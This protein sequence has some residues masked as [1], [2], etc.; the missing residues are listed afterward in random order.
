M[1]IAKQNMRCFSK[2]VDRL[3]SILLLLCG[4]VVFWTISQVTAFVSFRI[5]SD[6]MEPALLPGDNILVNKWIMGGRIF[7]IWDASEKKDVKIFRLSGL[8][9]VKRNDILVF[10]FPY[11][12]RWDSLGLNLKTYY[13]KR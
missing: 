9:K 8:G 1:K 11:S 10:N 4:L 5:P 6:S 12:G 7:D 3:L 13:V 2:L